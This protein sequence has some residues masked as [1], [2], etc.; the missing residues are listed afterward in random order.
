MNSVKILCSALLALFF[1]SG[2]L[3]ARQDAKI[4]HGS[5]AVAAFSILPVI[6]GDSIYQL[7]RGY[8]LRE[9]ETVW[10]DSLILLTRHKDYEI[11]YDRGIIKLLKARVESLVLDSA[12]HT[13]RVKF[14]PLPFVFKKEYVLRDLVMKP[15]SAGVQ[16]IFVTEPGLHFE[17]N[18][19]FGKG[20]QKSG[21]LMRGFTIGSN[22]DLAL[23]SGFRMQLNGALSTDINVSAAL[24]DENSPIQ[25]EGTTQTLREVDKVFVKVQSKHLGATLGDFN[26]DVGEN[27]GGEFGRLSRKLQGASGSALFENLAPGNLSAT[28]ALTA[29]TARGKFATNYFQGI[30]GNQGPYRLTG[31]NGE[32]QIVVVAGTER[33]Y[34]NGE[35]MTRGELNDYTI[36]YASGD[37]VFT[38]RRMITNASRI[39]IDFEYSDQQYTRNLLAVTTGETAW[40]NK[41]KINVVVAQEADDPDSPID[42]ALD[43]TSRHVLKQSGADPLRASLPGAKFVGFDSLGEAKGQYVQRDTMINGKPYTILTYAPGDPAALYSVSFSPVQSMPAD[44]AGYARVASGQYQFVGIGSGNFLPIQL[45]PMP[46]LHR[47]IDVNGN[48]R[49]T[50]DLTLSGEYA[51][52]RFDQNRFSP[53]DLQSISGGAMKFGILYNPKQLM[54]FGHNYGEFNL[55]VSDRHV[56]KMFA[57]LDRF[58]NV[59]FAREW[60]L[61]NLTSS[62]EEIRE[63]SLVYKPTRSLSVG[64]GYGLLDRTGETKSLRTHGELEMKDSTLPAVRYNF[65]N[66]SNNDYAEQRNS[67]WLRQYATIDY[68]YRDLTPSLRVTSE[69]RSLYGLSEDSLFPGAFKILEVSPRLGVSILGPMSG[70]IEL[71]SRIEDS[72]ANGRLNRASRS[73]TQMYALQLSEW[74]DLSSSLGFNVRSVTYSDLFRNRGNADGEFILIRSQSRYAPFERAIES[75]LYYEFASQ[76]SSRLE[77]VYLR[78]PKGSGNYIYVGDLNGNGIADDNE[79]QLTK[80]DGDYIV[81]YVP[82]ETLYPVVN[83]KSSVRLRVQ[84]ARILRTASTFWERALKSVSTETYLRVEENSSDPNTRHIYLMN[85]KY[86]QNDSTTISGSNQVQ[87]D[88]FLFENDPALSFRFRY[89]Q[90]NGF[91]QLVSSG[92][93]SFLREQSARIRS[94]LGVDIGN[95]TDVVNK[96]DRVLSSEPST[97]ERDITSNSITSDF[98][99]RPE[100]RWEIGF[101]F[102]VSRSVDNFNSGNTTADINGQGI[103]ITYGLL[104][105]GQLRSEFSREEVLLS[106]VRP[107]AVRGIPFELTNGDAI[108]KNYLWQLAFDYRISQ[109]MQVSFQYNGR[110]EGG[111]PPVHLA[112]AEARAFF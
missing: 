111:R 99:Y 58:N 87:Q 37:V 88:L 39:T 71:Q 48:Y 38:S 54:L 19:F 30:D 31:N 61:S 33:V 94:Q 98:S 85:F 43:D 107:D 59:E 28:G 14:L 12:H 76:R 86:F 65:E 44:S 105:A 25:P 106:N 79:F 81:I 4:S 21:T 50:E 102:S 56:D 51:A 72:S 45:L 92:E 84:P 52:S 109:N 16:R 83:L 2:R 69:D 7:P 77:R 13:L 49:M 23:N 55:S 73:L 97:R 32:P 15:D 68:H 24:T 11:N 46:Q 29:A 104:G 90:T 40:N 66:I 26:L 17:P 95:Q 70:S 62:D 112:R 22:Q 64:G 35:I 91:V 10:M 9:S 74:R 93:R 110:S 75:D 6:P 41:L 60:N 101:N 103:R 100:I 42:F 108:G 57:P 20:I 78:V 89:S 1:L 5:I 8:I 18:E 67:T 82:S 96:T 63:A 34:L 47:I 36:D 53:P 3:D 27:Q 80:Y